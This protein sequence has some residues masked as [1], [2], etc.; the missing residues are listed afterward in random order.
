MLLNCNALSQSRLKQAQDDFKKHVKSLHEMKKD[1]DYI[2][3]KI[4]NMKVKLSQQYPQAY[5][6][7][8]PQR[9]TLA[10]EAEDD[11]VVK[12]E[13]TPTSSLPEGNSQEKKDDVTVQYVKMEERPNDS[14][15]TSEETG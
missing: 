12:E 5:I 7:A 3:K 14:D 8:L 9:T 4:R 6:D 10:E 1:L 2:F 11:E 15:G 13:E